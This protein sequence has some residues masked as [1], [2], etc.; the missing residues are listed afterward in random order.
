MD[1]LADRWRRP[2]DSRCVGNLPTLH[3]H[4]QIDA[5]EHTP[6][7]GVEIVERF[8]RGHGMS[9]PN[10]AGGAFKHRFGHGATGAGD[11][12]RI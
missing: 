6:A 8:V 2:L 9:G 11:L 1:Q 3:R 7:G 4:V 5:Q 10:E 12:K